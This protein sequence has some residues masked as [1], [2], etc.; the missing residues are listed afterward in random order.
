MPI[1]LLEKVHNTIV[2]AIYKVKVGKNID[3]RGRIFIR[4][5]GKIAIGDDF[6]CNCKMAAN[7]VGGPYQTAFAVK[8]VAELT[9]G[10]HVGISGTAITFSYTHLGTRHSGS[11]THTAEDD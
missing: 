2:L 10:N 11:V 7:P 4:N 3:I 6:T 9:I 1:K 8:A 5:H